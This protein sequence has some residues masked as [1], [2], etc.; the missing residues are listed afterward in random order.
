MEQTYANL[1]QKMRQVEQTGI[2][3]TRY[4]PAFSTSFCEKDLVL[5]NCYL[6]I[7]HKG[8][9]RALYDM[10]ETTLC[11]NMAILVMS[12]HL[13]RFIE[14]SDDLLFTRL[15][16][17][18]KMFNEMLCMAFSH[19]VMKYHTHPGYILT[20]EQVTTL[21]KNME[22]LETI[23]RHDENELPHR[24]Q[25]ILT[26]L[27]IAFECI[28][29]YRNEQAKNRTDSSHAELLNRFCDLVVEHFR[30]SREVKFYAEKL[31][32]HPYHLTRVIR[33]ISGGTTPADWIEQYV[34]T[35]AKKMIE[36]QPDQPLKTVAYELGFS[37]P[38]SFYRY[39]KH[40]TGTTAKAYRNQKQTI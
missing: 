19:D 39:F 9:A 16:I 36:A 12:G 18:Q 4:E 10:H 5:P 13:I 15:V 29:Y 27:T 6:L 21:M 34:I 1:T 14:R 23:A 24:R 26:Q 8:T 22:L 17:S 35:Q 20:D 25:L 31:N 28:N 30:E 38:T 2:L 11:P 32:L 33:D 40:A 37:E 7:V 3:V